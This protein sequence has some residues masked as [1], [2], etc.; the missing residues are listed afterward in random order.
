M[1]APDCV[2]I[3][4]FDE[5]TH[6]RIEEHVPVSAEWA[7]DKNRKRLLD[8]LAASDSVT[9]HYQEVETL[10][11]RFLE[12]AEK[13]DRETAHMSSP[14]QRFTHPSYEAIRGMADENR[15]ELIDLLLQDMQKHRRE[16]FW[17]LSYLT[18]ENPVEGKDVGKLDKTINAWVKWGQLR[19]GR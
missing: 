10:E 7:V 18:H 19:R 3:S 13:W 17:M 1:F 11:Q 12:Q 8:F 16:W 9:A 5:W 6:P 15:Q 14:T 4:Q 2:P